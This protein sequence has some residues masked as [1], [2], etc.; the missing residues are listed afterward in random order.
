MYTFLI[1]I[2][3]MDELQNCELGMLHFYLGNEELAGPHY[4]IENSFAST[5]CNSEKVH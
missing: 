5:Y 1:I 2:S 4:M 3:E